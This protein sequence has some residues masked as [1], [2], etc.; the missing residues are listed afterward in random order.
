MREINNNP[1]GNPQNFPAKAKIEKAKAS[2]E[3]AP[4]DF[5]DCAQSKEIKDFLND[6]GMQSLVKTDNLKNDI[7]LLLQEPEIVTSAEVFFNRT[8][9]M[10]LENGTEDPYELAAKLT[11]VFVKEFA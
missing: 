3:I 10:L 8:Y 5:N 11:D 9:N 7:Q 1:T 6:P 2:L 4:V